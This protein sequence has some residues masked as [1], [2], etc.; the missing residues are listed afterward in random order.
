[1]NAI[2]AEIR[3]N[4]A[5]VL[6]EDGRFIRIRN[7]SY[8]VGQRVTLTPRMQ[9][10]RQR[11]QAA[12]K[13]APFWI[14]VAAALLLVAGVGGTAGYAYYTPYA[15]VSLDVNPSVEMT[16]NRFLRVL[17]IRAVND[18]G[19]EIVEDLDLHSLQY[20]SV[21]TAVE[22]T[23]S[24]IMES[25]YVAQGAD[26]YVVIAARAGS[27]AGSEALAQTAT[28]GVQ[29]AQGVDGGEL[30]VVSFT[31][32]E[33]EVE[34][35]HAQDV[36]P[37]KMRIVQT[38]EDAIDDE[39]SVDRAYWLQQPVRDI[40]N[41]RDNQRLADG[42]PQT[43]ES[44]QPADTQDAP[45][46]AHGTDRPQQATHDQQPAQPETAA[47]RQPSAPAVATQATSQQTQ[48]ASASQ[49]PAAPTQ[50]PG[51]AVTGAGTPSTA[52]E[53]PQPLP[54]ET[55][56]SQGGQALPKEPSEQATPTVAQPSP[57][58]S[59]SAS[60]SPSGT[61]QQEAEDR[62]NPTQNRP[63]ISISGPLERQAVPTGLPPSIK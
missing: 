53:T 26:N 30:M 25:D 18:A 46:Q 33:D 38:L 61:P 10:E 15:Y 36:T 20:A 47:T 37:G 9:A 2:I 51:T 6:L 56:P 22:T 13:R 57:S 19:A 58:P 55:E 60:S 54:R 11:P 5:A 23:V 32:T 43:A 35:A 31:V 29:A 52:K 28:Q 34:E 1:M 44:A 8:V 24:R 27:D 50:Q 63:S 17:S 59:P 48:A 39:A 16:L 12:R 40:L 4:Q 7:R 21:E 41:E 42:E 62:Q 14:S 3:G 45:R 49:P